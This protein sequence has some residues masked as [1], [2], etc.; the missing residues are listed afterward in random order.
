MYEELQLKYRLIE[1]GRSEDRERLKE[2]ERLKEDA[3]SWVV[4][5]PKLQTRLVELSAEV[6]DLRRLTKEAE[7]EREASAKRLEDLN[8]QLEMAALD[9]EMAEE[10]A[11][12]AGMKLEE[13]EER[14]AELKVEL[15]VMRNEERRIVSEARVEVDADPNVASG[16]SDNKKD[17]LA[18]IQLAKQNGRMREAL[19]K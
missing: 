6:K 11:E 8:D 7:M 17:S 9:K 1:T 5:R 15:D 3:E 2:M 4:A 16:E 13:A 14:T 12:D 18:F 19:V 10:K